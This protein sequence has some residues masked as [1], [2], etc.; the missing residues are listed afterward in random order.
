MNGQICPAE[1]AHVSLADRGLTLGDGLFETLRVHNGRVCHMDLH[2]QRL[3]NGGAVLELSV[4]NGAVVAQAAQE[5]LAVT[6]IQN[7]SMRLTVTRGVAP[8]GLLPPQHE[9]PT[10]FMTAAEGTAKVTAM[11]LMTSQTIRRDERSPLN[12]VKSLNY[13]PNI[14]AR[15]E[16][17]RAACGD[18]LLL[19]LQGRIAETTVSTVIIQEQGGFITPPVSE[20][21]LPGV[22]RAVL[23]RAGMLREEMISRERLNFADGVYLINSLS[24]RR[25]KTVDGAPIRHSPLG[26]RRVCE[27]FEIPF[28]EGEGA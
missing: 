1:A 13:L 27:Q 7:G 14:L 11:S 10:I 24:V 3:Q 6:G 4:P 18:A 2:M 21:A 20:G 16:A 5:L 12:S 23:L 26:L 25:V 28:S 22:A 8:R 19:N 15:Q 17:E 9:Q